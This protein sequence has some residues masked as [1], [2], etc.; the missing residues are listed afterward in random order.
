MARQGHDSFVNRIHDPFRLRKEIGFDLGARSDPISRTHDHGG[1]I[2]FV[3]GELTEVR[4]DVMHNRTTLAGIRREDDLTGLADRFDERVVIQGIDRS[5]I[6]E[7]NRE[8][9]LIHI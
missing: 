8:L 5:T 3:K 2:Q 6:E 9:S 1:S 4:C 7:I